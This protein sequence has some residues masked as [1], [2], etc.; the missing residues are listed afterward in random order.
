MLAPERPPCA[1][2]CASTLRHAPCSTACR[3][4]LDRRPRHALPDRRLH[5][6][7]R[8]VRDNPAAEADTVTIPAS[9]DNTLYE[10][11][12]QD[13]FADRQ[14]RSGSDDV[15]G[16]GQ[17][18]EERG[19]PGRDPTR[20]DRVRHRRQH[21]A[22]CDHRQRPADAVLRQ[23]RTERELQRRAAP[24]ARGVGTRAR[25]TPATHSR[26][27]ASQRRRTTRPGCT[28]STP[29]VLDEPRRRLRRDGERNP[30][31][32]TD[33]DLHVGLDLRNGRRRPGLAGRRLPEPRLDHPQ[34]R[35][36][37]PDD[38]ALRDARELD[39]QQSAEA[40]SQLHTGGHHR[41]LLQRRV[42]LAD[43]AGL[44]R[45]RLP[46]RRQQLLT[47]SMRRADRRLLRSAGPAA[48]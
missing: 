9:K 47:K 37:D 48:R 27:A 4:L 33:R 11:I 40:G 17:G 43:D 6:R 38:E 3:N 39:R 35:V 26:D 18:C 41:R 36:R 19:G 2:R 22:G 5:R 16:Q 23:G 45:R 13:G 28:R 20:R 1:P 7:P 24:R 25:R 21:P 10:P 32:R 30:R 34:Q 29:L 42:L 14:R 8:T 46:G 12:E 44:V 31:R 15:H